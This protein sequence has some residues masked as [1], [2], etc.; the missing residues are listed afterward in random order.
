LLAKRAA[1]KAAVVSRLQ[2]IVN[3]ADSLIMLLQNVHGS[4]YYYD[5]ISQLLDLS[6]QLW[7]SDDSFLSFCGEG[8]RKILSSRASAKETQ[9][10]L[11]S[12][13]KQMQRYC[14]VTK[15]AYRQIGVYDERKQG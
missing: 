8:M 15:I 2:E 1:D 12:L 10:A 11:Y 14:I 5:K 13:T 4:G 9:N 3:E 6:C 7:K